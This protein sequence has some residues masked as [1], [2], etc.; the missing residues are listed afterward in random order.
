MATF[1]GA[2]FIAEQLE[3]FTKQTVPPDELVVTDDGSVDHTLEIITDFSRT[4]SFRV[5]LERNPHRL[6]YSANFE[7]AIASCSGDIIFI[8]DQDDAWY[9]EKIRTVVDRIAC[10]A[11][12][13]VTVNDQRIVDAGGIDQHMTMFGNFRRAGCPDTDLIAGSCTAF[14]RTLLSILLPFPPGMPYDSWIGMVADSLGI[15]RLIEEP[16]QL[17]RRHDSNATE[18]IVATRRPTR[19][20]AFRKYGMSNPRAAW[21][22]EM[23]WRHDLIERLGR[24]DQLPSIVGQS[25]IDNAVDVNRRRI[26][27]LKARQRLL[28]LS[29]VPRRIK[30]LSAYAS[31]LYKN[32][33]GFRSALKDMVRP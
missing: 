25:A 14:P 28:E 20:S 10:E 16:L 31:G 27:A 3:S 23:A 15:K 13:V 19:W 30:I 22:A 18:P 4:A 33:D 17:Y 5:R 26:H 11:V 32:F 8:S 29:G 24:D 12:P 2:R 9:P 1:N 6:G 21:L 7:R